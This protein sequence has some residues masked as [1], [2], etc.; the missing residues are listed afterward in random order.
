[1]D[2]RIVVSALAIGA[3]TANGLAAS[4]FPIATST[5]S[6]RSVMTDFPSRAEY[7]VVAHYRVYRTQPPGAR[8]RLAVLQAQTTPAFI[9]ALHAV[10]VPNAAIRYPDGS[11]Q[12]ADAGGDFDAAASAYAR[13][14]PQRPGQPDVAVR[15]SAPAR[16]GLATTTATVA[17]PSARAEAAT[18]S[19]VV[20]DGLG[21]PSQ[22]LQ[23]A[24]AFSCD[25]GQY[26][27]RSIDVASGS[28]WKT[29]TFIAAASISYYPLFGFCGVDN[30]FLN[31]SYVTAERHWSQPSTIALTDAQKVPGCGRPVRRPL[32]ASATSSTTYSC[33]VQTWS[34]AVVF[35]TSVGWSAQPDVALWFEAWVFNAFRSHLDDRHLALLHVR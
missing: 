13:A 4:A 14:R 1:M 22:A 29:P 31:A 18:A 26:A 3:F 25:A 10:P 16:D 2:R 35:S 33:T 6:A 12:F 30:S 5:G 17:A 32:V 34:T 23:P 8:A 9:A 27:H 11:V 21:S 28:T 7:G 15:V 19:G 20:A 24:Y